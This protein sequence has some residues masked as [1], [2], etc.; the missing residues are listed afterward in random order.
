MKS[1][2]LIVTLGILTSLGMNAQKIYSVNS[3]SQADVK[4][5]VV[6]KDY[7][8]DLIVYK[9]DKRRTKASGS[10]PTNPIELTRKSTS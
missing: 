8:A 10:L 1:L 4:V 9:T 7:R 2:C 5:F 3:P 6:D